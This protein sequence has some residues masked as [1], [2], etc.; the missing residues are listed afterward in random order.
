MKNLNF[1]CFG[2]LKT[3]GLKPMFKKCQTNCQADKHLWIRN[4]VF[5]Y[6]IELPKENGKRRYFCKSLHTTNYYEAQE[7]IKLMSERYDANDLEVKAYIVAAKAI[8]KKMVFD[9]YTEQNG[10]KVI[11]VSPKTDPQILNAAIEIASKQLD[12]S[13]F[14]KRDQDFMNTFAKLVGNY[15]IEQ[16]VFAKPTSNPGSNHTIEEIMESMLKKAHNVK[17]V[18]QNKRSLIKKM[19]EEVGLK[20]TD[21]YLDFYKQDII[22]KIC[23]NIDSLPVTGSVKR[24]HAR[25]IK[26]LIKHANYIDPD[27]YKTNLLNLIPEFKKTRKDE[28]KPHWPYSN[29]EL[30]QIFNPQ[31]DFFK[32]YPDVFWAI[33]IGLFFGARTN[34]AITLQ[35]ADIV[36]IDGIDCVKFQDTHPLKQLKNDASRRTVPI[37]LQLLNLG[38][39]DYLKHQQSK[40]KAKSTDFIFPRCQTKSGQ[41]SNKFT[42]RGLVK[43]INNI[44]ITKNNSNKLDFHS[45]RKNANQRLEE[46]GVSETFINDIIGWE[47]KSTRQQSYSNHDLQKIKEQADKLCYDFLQT[48]F[49]YWKK[50][51]S[52]I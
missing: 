12:L 44:G 21:K 8:M 11:K 32:K 37:P 30:K 48:E 50:V 40:L 52:K 16:G 34:A 36:N 4:N 28:R 29:D 33:L 14:S 49:D 26:N 20:L 27:T 3:K 7:R 42:T 45:L 31:Y 17:S 25:E 19:V 41:Y 47:G 39:V 10:N 51:M 13:R 38:F 23:D 15:L 1:F 46:V 43:H 18:E 6:M 9:V 24:N 35:Y 5:Y 22:Q 2:T